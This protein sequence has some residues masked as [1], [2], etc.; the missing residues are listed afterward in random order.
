MASTGD[1][2]GY[3][4][5]WKRRGAPL[6]FVIGIQPAPADYFQVAVPRNSAHPNAAALFAAFLTTPEAQAIIDEVSF[7]GAHLSPDTTVARYIKESGVKIMDA[8]ELAKFFQSQDYRDI[9]GEMKKIFK[10]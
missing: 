5:L 9:Y 1:A 10:N 6:D 8:Q 2:P 3:T 4:A 7:Q